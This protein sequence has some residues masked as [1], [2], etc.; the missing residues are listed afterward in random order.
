M[1]PEQAKN[2]VWF[3]TL[4]DG[5]RLECDSNAAAWS[6]LIAKR[7]GSFGLAATD[8]GGSRQSMRCQ[9]NQPEMNK[10]QTMAKQMNWRRA[11]L[12][13]RPS[14]DFRGEFEF[15]DR[16]MR[17]LK[18]VERKQRERRQLPRGRRSVSSGWITTSSSAA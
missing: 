5:Q 14:I 11:Q 13:G 7:G 2:R 1:T 8:N 3:V 10:G 4:P 15:E 18:A 9:Q 16:A 6:G 17:W 12:H